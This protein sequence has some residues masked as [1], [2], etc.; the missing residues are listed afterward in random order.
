MDTIDSLRKELGWTFGPDRMLC[1]D[2]WREIYS[3]DA[4]YFNIKP[5]CVVRPRTEEEVRKVLAAASR[6]GIGVTF[7]AG[8][9]SLSGQTLGQGI[10]CE[11]RTDWRRAEVRRGGKGIWFEP[12]LTASQVNAILRPHRH[13]IGP[14]PASSDAAMMGGVLSNNSSGMTAGVAH[15]AYHTLASMRF[16]T[17]AGRT[18]DSA[19][20]ADRRR[21]ATD[22]AELCRGLLE[23]RREILSDPE[24]M[25]KINRKYKIK[26]V[27]GYA[28]NSFVDYDDPMDIFIHTLIGSEGTLGFILSAELDT[29][30]LYDRYS[31]VLLYFKDV[32]SA[33]AAAAPLG[34]T[35]ALAVEIMDYG[36][37]RASEG[38][39]SDLPE[40][41]TALLLD[42]GADSDEELAEITRK[43]AEEI[44][45][46]KGLLGRDPF[47]TDVA[48]R[49]RLWKIRDGVFPCVA[50]A[51]NP[52]SAV[53]LEDVAAPVERLADLVDGVQALF[54]AHSYPGAIFGHARAGNI[55]PLVTPNIRDAAS[56][57]NFRRFIEQFV[58]CVLRLDG[59]LK[60]EHG[61]G[62]A[63]APFVAREWGNRIYSMMQ[64]LKK[65]ADPAG[66]L[67]PGVII[68]SDPECFIRPI[69]TFDSF[70]KELG[71]DIAD[72]C[73]ECGY[74]EHVCPSRDIT[75]TPRQRLQARRVIART[76]SRRLEKEYRYIGRDTCCSDASCRI[77]CPMHINTGDVTDAVRDLTNPPLFK[78]ALTASAPR[79]RTIQDV[80]RFGLKTAV[81]AE[82]IVT[83][84][85]LEAGA[86]LL[87]TIIPMMPHW[88]RHFPAPGRPV[89][90]DDPDASMVYFPS[91]VT[92]IFGSS[93]LGKDDL[94][95]TVL[96]VADRAGVSLCVPRETYGLCCSQ[97]WEHK[98][99]RP[100]QRIAANRIVEAF[101]RMSSEGR[102]PILCDTTS[103]THTLLSLG[104]T[105]DVLTPENADHYRRLRIVDITRWLLD[106]VMP[107]LRVDRPKGRILLHPTCA[108]RVAGLDKAFEEVA[109]M[110][111]RE[112]VVPTDGHC[113]GA[114]GDRGFIYPEVARSAVRDEKVQADASAPY[115]GCYSLACTCEISMRDTMGL[116]FESV[117][118]L[119]DETT[120]AA[121]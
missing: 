72:K 43:A 68:N 80:F 74:C 4:S 102:L 54:R 57:D 23:I 90:R 114:A 25:E 47:T 118:Y 100:G 11:L 55:H 28:M 119:I 56:T 37:I 61:T 101:W 64:R 71:V 65:L 70:G 42:Y 91:C 111:A 16:M 1:S 6:R 53:I 97:I 96:R 9:T 40:G 99:D 103:C 8:G 52:G 32:T 106:T 34:K 107:G 15:N 33:A 116:P 49:Q 51:R 121:R 41:A 20:A 83:P 82:K 13:H 63:M 48:E 46:Q 3:R 93:T 12:G 39:K 113:C 108:S 50:G 120:V 94:V 26:N 62:R 66:I 19:S 110:C 77:P 45:R 105:T 58:D 7:R 84:V 86:D 98:G 18:Y 38:M 14:D 29:L 59:S 76:G 89:Y 36:S 79:Y 2:L 117:A 81:M 78:K 22:E 31:S 60:G 75:L 88:S 69:K 104:A 92:R 21:F 5:L 115:D 95:T 109:R 27:T 30:P 85:P 73:M 35:G 17:A 87:H 10:V 24:T 44:D 112:V 67:N